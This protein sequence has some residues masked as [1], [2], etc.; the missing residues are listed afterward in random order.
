MAGNHCPA[1]C[2]EQT[3]GILYTAGSPAAAGGGAIAR[4]LVLIDR[5]KYI[6]SLGRIRLQPAVAAVGKFYTFCRG[7]GR[8]RRKLMK[9]LLLPVAWDL[10]YWK[11]T[12]L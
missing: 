8:L 1:K 6:A 4:K 9:T 7:T 5:D 3:V 12:R 11:T 10:L 2:V